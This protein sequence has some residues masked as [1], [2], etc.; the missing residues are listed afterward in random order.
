MR[1]SKKM[2]TTI[3][4]TIYGVYFGIYE[5][6]E[7]LNVMALCD[8]ASTQDAITTT[9]KSQIFFVFRLQIFFIHM[10][11]AFQYLS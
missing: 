7:M 10:D 3:T 4:D 5:I 1:L 2:A 11:L 9:T 6:N 8:N